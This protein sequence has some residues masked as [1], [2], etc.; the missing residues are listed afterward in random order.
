MKGV[1]KPVTL[2][3]KFNK[4]G[5]NPLNQKQTIGFSATAVIKRSEFGVN[6]AIPNISDEVQLM[7]EAEANL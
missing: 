4:S 2:N 3:V 6:Y 7:I 1:T 5:A